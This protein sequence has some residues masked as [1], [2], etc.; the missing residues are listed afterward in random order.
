MRIQV[1]L[2]C[3]C[4]TAL[5]L[6][7][8]PA[9]RP[10]TWTHTRHRVGDMATQASTRILIFGA[11]NAISYIYHV[12]CTMRSM[13]RQHLSHA[14]VIVLIQIR[15]SDGQERTKSPPR[16]SRRPPAMMHEFPLNTRTRNTLTVLLKHRRQILFRSHFLPGS[17]SVMSFVRSVHWSAS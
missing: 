14:A 6:S 1:V 3:V 8:R 7:D 9:N 5:A 2:F 16:I 4:G 17:C 12:G 13:E 15:R 10:R 11:E